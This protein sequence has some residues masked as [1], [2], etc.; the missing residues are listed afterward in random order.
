MS[1]N[2]YQTPQGELIHQIDPAETAGFYVVS[3]KK[4]V[5]LFVITL[6][7]YQIYWF[8]RN[9]RLQKQATGEK[10]WP[11]ARAIF[12]IFFVH[13]LFRAADNQRDRGPVRLPVWNHGQLATIIVLLLIISHVMDRLSYKSIGS[14]VTD[15]VGLLIL[16]PI[17]A[18]FASAQG[19]INEACGDPLGES[20]SKFTGANWL[21]LLIGG[22]LWA[23]VGMGLFGTLEPV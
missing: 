6:G 10:I 2:P 9:W 23:L 20:N 21:W 19:R 14:P 7:S 13:A 15:L 17:A 18:C 3:K 1:D 4:M 11:L 16:C 8:Y 5:V 12:S 22:I